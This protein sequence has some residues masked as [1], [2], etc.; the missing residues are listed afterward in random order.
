SFIS[1]INGVTTMQI[2]SLCMAGTWKH[3]DLPPPVGIRA[4]VSLPA[5]TDAMISDCK[6]LNDSY[7]QYFRRIP[8]LSIRHSLYRQTYA[9]LFFSTYVGTPSESASASTFSMVES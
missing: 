6:G 9:K 8:K 3:R 7:F 5:N 1:A 4:S 2:P